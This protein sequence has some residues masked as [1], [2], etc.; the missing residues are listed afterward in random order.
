VARISTCAPARAPGSRAASC[1]PSS[2]CPSCAATS[3]SARRRLGTLAT[4]PIGANLFLDGGDVT[5]TPEQLDPWNLYW[6][7]GAG[8]WS[9]LGGVLKFRFEVGYRLNR[10]AP[11]DPLSASS[12]WDKL[13]LQLGV[14]ENY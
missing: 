1:A 12:A 4:W 11:P 3:R 7:V 13:A 8:L 9:K 2:S 5:R 6:A 10:T 14:G